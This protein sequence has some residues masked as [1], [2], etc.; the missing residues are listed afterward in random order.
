LNASS[1]EEEAQHEYA[2]FAGRLNRKEKLLKLHN[3]TKVSNELI[4]EIIR[5]S[6]P[7]DVSNFDVE[8]KNSSITGFAGMAYWAGSSYHRTRS[9]FITIRV[10]SW[11]KYPYKKVEGN[12]YLPMKLFSQE[13]CIVMVIAHELRHLWQSKIPK[14]RKRRKGMVKGTKGAMS[15]RDADAYAYQ[16]VRQ[17]RRRGMVWRSG[18]R[19]IM[20]RERARYI[21]LPD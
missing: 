10:G 21:Y 4:R 15:E 2:L 7:V 6:K 20:S 8:V 16:K 9:P 17:W 1:K 12:G 5:F 19:W 13:E 3:T 14:G 18:N 11:P